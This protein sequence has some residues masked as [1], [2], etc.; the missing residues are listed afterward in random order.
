MKKIALCALIAL[1]AVALLISGCSDSGDTSSNP[2]GE[3]V[4]ATSNESAGSVSLS[5][6][7]NTSSEADNAS[8]VSGENSDGSSD[9]TSGEGSVPDISDTTSPDDSSDPEVSDNTSENSTPSDDPNSSDDPNTSNDPGTSDDPNSSDDP[10]TSDDPDVSVPD[11]EIDGEGT[12][13][14]PYLALPDE[15]MHVTTFSIPAGKTVYYSIYRIGGMIMKINDSSAYVIYDGTTYT[16]KSGT[17]SLHIE[18]AMASASITLQIGNTSSEAK[19]FEI[20]FTNPEGTYMNPTVVKDITDEYTVS[21]EEE[22]STGYYFIYTAEKSGT[23][24]FTLTST[25][26]SMMTVTNNRN[27]AQ[28]TTEADGSA[29][30]DGTKYVEIE[31]EK[32]DELII[33]VGALPNKRGKYPAVDITWTSEYK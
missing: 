24:V 8:N 16:P 22:A 7:E 10:G 32:G 18:D 26:D 23:L 11:P 14:N 3:S 19:S 12:K 21:L 1:F 30:A 28:R 13:A 27:S 17:V 20:I 5:E 15:D 29:D 6:S 9:V 25:K 33:N 2:S 31:V 4:G